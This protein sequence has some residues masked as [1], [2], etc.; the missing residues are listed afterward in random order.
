MRESYKYLRQLYIE[1]LTGI[2]SSDDEIRLQKLLEQ[3]ELQ[4]YWENMH[5]EGEEL[6]TEKVLSAI[7]LEEELQKFK[8]RSF[9]DSKGRSWVA[10]T[11]WSAAAAILIGLFYF[12][13]PAN[14]MQ[15]AE[16][17]V[18]HGS[19]QSDRFPNNRLLLELENGES[20]YLNKNEDSEFSL[21]TDHFKM[22]GGQLIVMGNSESANRFNRLYVPATETFSV[23]MSDGTLIYLN[24]D[25]ELKFPSTF[26]LGERAVFISGEAY[27]E[28]TKNKGQNFVVHAADADVMVTGTSFNV[29]SYAGEKFRTALLEGE[30][31]VSSNNLNSQ[32]LSPG[33]EAEISSKGD[34]RISKFDQAEVLS[35]RDGTYYFHQKQLGELSS[36]ISRWFGVKV[37]IEKESL[38]KKPVSGMLEK[39]YLNDFLND[40]KSTAGIDYSLSDSILVLK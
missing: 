25:T 16:S 6:N 5:R 26:G 8:N 21:G 30:V 3:P 29:S 27:F 36:T 13:R 33:E 31:F 19:L 39:R 11:K 34:L 12:F 7:D 15:V 1:K 38:K 32:K 23:K 35:W 9:E 18:S 20:V 10:W 4:L 40:L 17:N 22:S 28:V 37:V 24:S 14:Q 2:I